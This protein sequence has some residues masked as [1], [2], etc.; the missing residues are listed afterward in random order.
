[1]TNVV[2]VPPSSTHVALPPWSGPQQDPLAIALEMLGFSIM[3]M[4]GE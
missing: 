4:G 3:P 1:V 2:D